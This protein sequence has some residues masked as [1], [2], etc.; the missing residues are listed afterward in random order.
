M[1]VVE[2]FEDVNL[3]LK[4]VEQLARAERLAPDRLDRDFKV[5]GLREISAGLGEDG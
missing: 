4:I 3:G 5:R 1:A 2:G